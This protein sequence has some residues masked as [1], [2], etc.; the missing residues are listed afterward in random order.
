VTIQGFS[1][2]PGTLT[3]TAGTTVTWTNR[4][5]AGH[6]ATADDASFNSGRL[7]NGASFGQTFSTAGT[8]TYHCAI[9][10]DMTGTIVV[11]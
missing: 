2:D 6:T 7:A 3:I 8:Y 9:H 11:Q 10:P 4:D 1:F 5:N